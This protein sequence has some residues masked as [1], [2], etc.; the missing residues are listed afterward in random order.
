M[1]NALAAVLAFATAAVAAFTDHRTGRIPNALTVPAFLAGLALGGD[2]ALAGMAACLGAPLFLFARGRLGAGDVKLLGA[3]GALLGARDG[4]TLE[5]VATGL[6]FLLPHRRILH[7]LGPTILVATAIAL[8]R[9]A[10]T[11]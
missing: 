9:R 1:E 7:R 10:L 6:F 8:L 2:V 11:C 3:L 4:V 5:L